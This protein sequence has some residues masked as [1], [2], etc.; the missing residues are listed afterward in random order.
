[1]VNAYSFIYNEI[2]DMTVQN[3][4][5]YILFYWIYICIDH[6]I[7]GRTCTTMPKGTLRFVIHFC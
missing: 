2:K 1:M 4:S 5:M 3:M 6:A 7:G